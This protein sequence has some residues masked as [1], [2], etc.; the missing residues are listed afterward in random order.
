M[1]SLGLYANIIQLDQL[2]IL[3]AFLSVFFKFC[4]Y[5]F[6]KIEFIGI[7]KDDNFFGWFF[8]SFSSKLLTVL[9][10][11]WSFKGINSTVRKPILSFSFK[12][13]LCPT[14]TFE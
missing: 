8:L 12:T 1:Y 4:I 14:I 6:L 7:R 10:L 9:G 2:F 3:V 13:D 11:K 5:L